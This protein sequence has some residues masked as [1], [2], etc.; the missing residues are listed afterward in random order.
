MKLSTFMSTRDIFYKSEH[1]G[2]KNV[3]FPPQI[4][5]FVLFY[6]FFIEIDW[7]SLYKPDCEWQ[8]KTLFRTHISYQCVFGQTLKNTLKKMLWRHFFLKKG[9]P[10]SIQQ[11]S[12]AK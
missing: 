3:N 4:K 5:F 1:F 12:E 8:T 11:H 9:D 7:N 6:L 10:V 2:Y